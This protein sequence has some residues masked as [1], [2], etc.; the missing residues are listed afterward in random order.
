M[1]QNPSLLPYLKGFSF[2]SAFLAEGGELGG[3]GVIYEATYFLNPSDIELSPYFA[4]VAQN[5]D[6]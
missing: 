3:V 5:Q 2:R 4:V 1:A 6:S